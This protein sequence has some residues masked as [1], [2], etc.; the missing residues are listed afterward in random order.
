MARA[1]TAGTAPNADD[2]A[3][4]LAENLRRYIEAGRAVAR[5][6]DFKRRGLIMPD[7]L[8]TILSA[9]ERDQHNETSRGSKLRDLLLDDR[10][11]I[12]DMFEGAEATVARDAMRRLMLTPV[13]DELTKRSL[14]ARI[15]KLYPELESVITGEQKEE[16][17]D[18]LI[19]SWSAVVDALI[20]TAH[21]PFAPVV[22]T[23]ELKVTSPPLL[24]A[25]LTRSP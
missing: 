7:L 14:L 3:A 19:V 5:E 24:V 2:C 15:I 25:K 20:V 8:G 22:Q 1:A 21:V 9:L 23:V 16:K 18:A 11:L 4:P 17:S 6:T 12:P 13:F 10:E